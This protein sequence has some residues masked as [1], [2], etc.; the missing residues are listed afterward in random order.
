MSRR[1]SPYV[2]FHVDLIQH[3]KTWELADALGESLAH[4]LG[5]L[6]MLWLW[7][8]GT[9]PVD[10]DLSRWKPGVIARAAQWEGDAQEFVDTLIETGWI[11]EHDNGVLRLHEAAIYA[12]KV[13]KKSSVSGDGADTENEAREREALTPA[14]RQ[15][16]AR[17]KKAARHGVTTDVTLAS[18]DVTT[19]VTDSH[20]GVTER[21]GVTEVQSQTSHAVT[22]TQNTPVQY[23]DA[24][25]DG[26]CVTTE[27]TPSVTDTQPA[28]PWQVGRT[29]RNRGF[30][31]M[32]EARGKEAAKEAILAC[33]TGPTDGDSPHARLAAVLRDFGPDAEIEIVNCLGSWSRKYD[34]DGPAVALAGITKWLKREADQRKRDTLNSEAAKARASKQG[35]VVAPDGTPVGV[36]S[37]KESWD[38]LCE[39]DWRRLTAAGEDEPEIYSE[40]KALYRSHYASGG[41]SRW[42]ERQRAQDADDAPD[43][44]PPVDTRPTSA[45][46]KGR[47]K[48]ITDWNA[49]SAVGLEKRPFK[50]YIEEHGDYYARGGASRWDAHMQS[51]LERADA[52]PN[53]TQAAKDAARNS[54]DERRGTA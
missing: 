40:Y 11:D 22:S 48:A 14:Q 51:E 21:H 1:A 7:A 23:R 26:A 30:M 5:H 27:V 32:D 45:P 50:A 28:I 3:P 18:R 42:E 16:R 49:F 10:A 13:T 4:T 54:R 39:H 46:D 37:A 9:L 44:A 41:T 31:G 6:G 36:G 24:A 52:P 12:S 20:A 8:K 35:I 29:P 25:R 43:L 2:P 53:L 38:A 34:S 19:D 33:L 17:E 15:K 47:A